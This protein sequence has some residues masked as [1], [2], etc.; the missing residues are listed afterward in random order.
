MRTTYL[1]ISILVSC[2]LVGVPDLRA[3]QRDNQQDELLGLE[4]II[5]VAAKREQSLID[6]PQS[7]Q[8]IT[9][10]ML[11]DSNIRDIAAPIGRLFDM[12]QVEILKGP[13]STLYGQGARG[14]RA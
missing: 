1:I 11:V 13:Q 10:E 9:A 3:H 12:Q 14:G 7:L 2:L 5:V 6:V 8:V 4:E